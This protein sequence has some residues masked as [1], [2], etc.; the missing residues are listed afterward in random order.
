MFAVTR[1]QLPA[2]MSGVLLASLILSL[3][4][5]GGAR[6]ADATH[7]S[8]NTFQFG[9]DF[10]KTEMIDPFQDELGITHVH[11]HE[12]FG[13]RG[14]QNNSTVTDLLNGANSCG[15]SFVKA[16]YWNPLNTDAGTRNM[17]KRLSV[18]Y[19]GWGDVNNL[20]HIPQGAKLYGTDEDFRC[21]SG[22]AR[23]TPPYDCKADEFRIRVH[24]PEC[25]SG[26]GVHPRE[27]I[28]ASGGGCASGY[29]PIPRIRVAVHYHN[30]GGI[31]KEPLEVS[32]GADMMEDWSFMHADIWEVN[33]QAGFRNA[34]ERC[35]FKSQSTGEPHMCSP[36]AS[37]Q[38]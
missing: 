2:A 24:F 13:Y 36:P 7:K 10:V 25:W 34:I 16:A 6:S 1:L 26:D 20:V 18:Y 11:R 37:N 31:L 5:F 33:R 14:L 38:L 19:S 17:P 23:E 35:V 27:F 15:P 30:S 22:P 9:C 28:D 21:G 4:A 29:E 12:V 8:G 3:A 32:A